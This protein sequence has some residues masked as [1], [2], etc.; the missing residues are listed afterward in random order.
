MVRASFVDVVSNRCGADKA[1]GFD[2]WVHQQCVDRF[3]VA[4]DYVEHTVR[5][6]RF[7]EQVGHE[8]RRRWVN[9]AGLQNKGVAA[10][11]SD[12]EHPHR[13]HHGEVEG[14]DTRHYAQRL[15]HGPVVY[16]GGDLFGV[17]AFK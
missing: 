8:K 16:A 14:C 11:N 13:H 1:H 9:R 10:C 17:V 15:A 5:Q 4:L 3:F 12:G 2:I 7:F 6:A